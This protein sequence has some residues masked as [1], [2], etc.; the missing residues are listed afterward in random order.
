MVKNLK[1]LGARVYY[2]G[3]FE[4]YGYYDV[5]PRIYVISVETF[6]SFFYW[7]FICTYSVWSVCNNNIVK[8]LC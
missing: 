8:I 1:T 5:E 3:V 4:E 6:F 2:I 7:L